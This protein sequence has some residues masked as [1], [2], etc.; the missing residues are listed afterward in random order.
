MHPHPP[1][2]THTCH[3]ASSSPPSSVNATASRLRGRD[4]ASRANN[5][6]ASPPRRCA[7]VASSCGQTDMQVAEGVMEGL[8]EGVMEGVMESWKE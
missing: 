7:S 3:G 1:T 5:M 4:A 2:H 8:M 6:R